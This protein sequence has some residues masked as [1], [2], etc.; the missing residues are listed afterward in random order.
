MKVKAVQHHADIVPVDGFHD[1]VRLTERINRAVR[2]PYKFQR[3]PRIVGL[4]DIGQF[5][6]DF[7]GFLFN[8]TLR[9]VPDIKGRN[10]DNR[11]AIDDL[12]HFAKK[13]QIVLDLPI[14]RFVSMV[15]ILQRVEGIRFNAIPLKKTA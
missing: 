11:L 13:L 10:D 14:S 12:A 5:M 3:E 4:R 8:L 6:E 15:D 7:H 1:V 9:I 2:I